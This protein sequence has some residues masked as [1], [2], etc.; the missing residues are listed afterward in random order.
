V[1]PS[2]EAASRGDLILSFGMGLTEERACAP[3]P[4]RS[5]IWIASTAP[6]V[7]TIFVACQTSGIRVVDAT[8]GENCRVVPGN[9]TEFVA[10]AC[11]GKSW[12]DYVVDVR[13]IGDP[14]F[15][16]AKDFVAEWQC[17]GEE[18]LRR[19][20]VHREAGYG[21]IVHLTC[22]R[23]EPIPAAS[24][25]IHVVGAT[26]GGNCGVPH[27]NVTRAVAASCEGRGLC[28]YVVDY[29]VIGDP[30]FGC[31]KDFV[32]EWQCV[33]DA[34][35]RSQRVPGEAGFRSVVRL[36]CDAPQ[37]DGAADDAG[38]PLPGADPKDRDRSDYPL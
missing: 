13:A 37:D 19:E 14:A 28:D 34:S 3:G 30:R 32:A 11:D 35:V 16:C 15:G 26:Y 38:K 17:P 9:A 8:Y 18:R 27:G 36:T 6:I 24:A 12:C 20:L 25:G 21:S 23:A 1:L 5:G 2:L 7:A 29:K 33:G 10:D 31:K 4:R 22:V